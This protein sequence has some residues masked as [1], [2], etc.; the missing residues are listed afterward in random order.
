MASEP[1]RLSAPERANL[2]AFL[3][4]ELTEAESQAISG[5]MTH[6]PTIRRELDDLRRTWEM[7]D[8]LKLPQA[9]EA[10]TA[11][12]LSLATQGNPAAAA[13]AERSR[14]LAR[15]GMRVIVAAGLAG[16]GIGTGYAATRWLWPDPTARLARDLTIAERLDA[17]LDVGSFAALQQLHESPSFHDST[18]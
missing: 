5:K 13:F 14:A 15:I 10:L 18:P 8:Y 7:L 2:V 6:S 17:Y 9:N 12:T 3:D 16:L 1:P 11:R 4:G